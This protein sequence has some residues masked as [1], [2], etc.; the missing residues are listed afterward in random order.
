M[1]FFVFDFYKHIYELF[2]LLKPFIQFKNTLSSL[3]V[4][5]RTK[6]KIIKEFLEI[7]KPSVA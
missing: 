1:T 2:W 5:Y 6:T 4:M 3:F 7:V